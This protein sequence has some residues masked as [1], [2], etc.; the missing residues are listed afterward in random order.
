MTDQDSP[1]IGES[2]RPGT[3]KKIS[4]QE[5][6]LS[7]LEDIGLSFDVALHLGTLVSVLVYFRK[8]FWLMARALLFIKLP[9]DDDV[10]F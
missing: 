2:T 8:D 4:L 7:D 1:K 3:G 9:D 5:D 10:F 6:I